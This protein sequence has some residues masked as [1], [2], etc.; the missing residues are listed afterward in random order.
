MVHARKA[1]LAKSGVCYMHQHILLQD[2]DILSQETIPENNTTGR[3][4]PNS[5]DRYQATIH[6]V[7]WQVAQDRLPTSWSGNIVSSNQQAPLVFRVSVLSGYDTP[8]CG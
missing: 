5:L 7:L 4:N 3:D 1:M 8:T 2:T 6:G